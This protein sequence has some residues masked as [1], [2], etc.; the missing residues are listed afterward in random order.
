[1]SFKT[2]GILLL[3]FALMGSYAYFYVGNKPAAPKPQTTFMY[4]YEMTDIVRME[5]QYKGESTSM[6]WDND[7]S[8]WHFT[9]P[10]KGEVDPSRANGIRLLLSGPGTH[11]VFLQES[12]TPGQLKEYGLADPQVVAT[13]ALKDGTVHRVLIGDATPDGRNYY[14]KNDDSA[15]IY[16]VDFTWG[17][18]LIRFVQEPPVQK[19]PET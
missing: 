5:V 15:T 8:E 2:T 9:D 1:M 19:P 16:L 17:N 4:K 18:E 3:L 6:V 12:A 13:I 10:A 7:K 14:T 11:R